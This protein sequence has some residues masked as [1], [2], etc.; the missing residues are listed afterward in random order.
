MR[1]FNQDPTSRPT[2]HPSQSYEP[3]VGRAIQCAVRV[4]HTDWLK[5]IS[6]NEIR[7]LPRYPNTRQTT[8]TSGTLPKAPNVQDAP[9][10]I[11]LHQNAPERTRTH[12]NRP[13]APKRPKTHQNAPK[14][15]QDLEQAARI[16]HSRPPSKIFP[17]QLTQNTQRPLDGYL[18]RGPERTY[19]CVL[20]Y[21]GGWDTQSPL[22][23][24]LTRGPERTYICVLAY[25][26]ARGG[27]PPPPAVAAGSSSTAASRQ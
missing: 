2:D 11:I 25:L 9:T 8:Q 13:N 19:I 10:C 5:W 1:Q 26:G 24:Y 12:Q 23:G 22:D 15:M 17:A 6:S 21:L 16:T 3:P 7:I 20:V 14:G 27:P 4:D 18:T